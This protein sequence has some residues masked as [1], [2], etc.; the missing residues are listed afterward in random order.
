MSASAPRLEIVALEGVPDISPGDELCGIVLDAYKASR[1]APEAGDILVVA[2]K[3]VSKSE[4]RRVDLA[5]VSPSREAERLART[6][7]KDARV[8]E[9]ILSEAEEVMRARPGLIVVRH[10]LGYV[11]ANAGIDASNVETG[12]TESVLL[13][14]ENPDLSA[15]SLRAGIARRTGIE[16]GIV[17]GDSLGRAWR[18]GTIGT[19]LGVAGVTA[20]ADLR[21][22]PDMFGRLLMVSEVGLADQIASAAALAMGEAGERRPVALVRGLAAASEDPCAADLIRPREFDLF[23]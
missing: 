22:T 9:L 2:Q 18:L 6:T 17:I 14:P 10:R 21:G 5:T 13:L 4:G 1:L 7:E 8:I 12:G 3:I 20:L 19:A 15:A 11:L 16:V 23:P